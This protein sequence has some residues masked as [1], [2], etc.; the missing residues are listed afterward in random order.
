MHR[1]TCDQPIMFSLL[2][3]LGKLR[4]SD[5]T[6]VYVDI[7]CIGGLIIREWRFK[8]LILYGFD[9]N[10]KLSDL[11]PYVITSFTVLRNLI[12]MRIF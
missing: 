11:F 7:I 1:A 6:R 4:I 5:C 2:G 10:Y 8:V 9:E 3:E 12:I